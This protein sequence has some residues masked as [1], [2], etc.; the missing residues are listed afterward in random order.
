MAVISDYS[1]L[2]LL[3]LLTYQ[4]DFKSWNLFTLHKF[5]YIFAHTRIVF[6]MNT[7]YYFYWLYSRHTMNIFDSE[8]SISRY[9]KA[10]LQWRN[11][12]GGKKHNTEK[13]M[14]EKKII[15]VILRKLL[16]IQKLFAKVWCLSCFQ[17]MLTSQKFICSWLLEQK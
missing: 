10:N 14:S 12:M 13:N 16:S 7:I 4:V 15:K 5:I 17:G 8:L 2:C 11:K 6:I 3:I 9:I 1:R